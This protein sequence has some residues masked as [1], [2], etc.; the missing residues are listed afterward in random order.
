M[1]VHQG[2]RAVGTA[3]VSETVSKMASGLT[4]CQNWPELAETRQLLANA[5]EPDRW[6][7]SSIWA[8]AQISTSDGRLILR[9]SS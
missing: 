1:R 6:K 5:G 8:P 2:V 9:E 3:T 4:I 7:S